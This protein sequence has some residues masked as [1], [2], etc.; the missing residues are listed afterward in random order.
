MEY[1]D[2]DDTIKDTFDAIFKG[3][4]DYVDNATFIN[5][6]EHI[7][8]I[9][10]K[11][12]VRN[13]PEINGA[14]QVLRG[15][16]QERIAGLSKVFTTDNEGAAKIEE[17]REM[18]LT[19]GFYLVPHRLK[20]TE[21]VLAKKNILVDDSLKNCDD[22]SS[23]GGISIYFNKLGDKIDGSGRENM[24]YLMTDTLKI[25]EELY[26]VSGVIDKG[27][28]YKKIILSSLKEKDGGEE[29]YLFNPSGNELYYSSGKIYEKVGD[30]FNCLKDLLRIIDIEDFDSLR[31]HETN[32]LVPRR[33]AEGRNPILPHRSIQCIMFHKLT[34]STLRMVFEYVNNSSY[35]KGKYDRVWIGNDNSY[36]NLS[37]GDIIYIMNRRV[38]GWDGSVERPVIE[39]LS[40]GGH[41]PEI[42][43]QENGK[44]ETIDDRVLLRKEIMEEMKIEV[45][46]R[47]ITVL[48]DFYNKLSNEL[49][50]LCLTEL[51]DWQLGEIMKNTLG[52]VSENIDGV[53]LGL[54]SEV[55]E[56]YKDNPEWFAGGVIGSETN[57]TR[58]YQLVE[59]INNY[60]EANRES[61][62]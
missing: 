9:D 32:L 1:I 6:P 49:V 13:S 2:Y 39:L 44:F 25:L 30:S 35:G 48:G 20:K 29:D 21:V 42:Y 36:Q 27:N 38:G 5:D 40:A 53:Y 58:N 55:L 17:F 19:C 10:W 57:F 28:D 56:I 51:S 33:Y 7:K 50:T 41:I 62:I 52:N 23:A 12:V 43:N 26:K 16:N 3:H 24:K 46:D 14:Y 61:N 31:Y 8:N 37:A 45:D 34:D 15:L 54:F 60:I 59:K 11:E 47:E 4:K 22:W 18:G